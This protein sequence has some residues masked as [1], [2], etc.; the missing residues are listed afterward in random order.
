MNEA[1]ADSGELFFGA[2]VRGYVEDNPRR[3]V[4]R[5]WLAAQVDE[6][7]AK[8]GKPFVLLTAE[9]GAGKSAFMAQLAHDHPD[10]LRY[11]IRR[12]QAEPLADVSA[13]SLLLRIGYQLLA[14]SPELFSKEQLTL[15]IKQRIGEVAAQGE[16]VGVEVDKLITSPFVSKLKFE[17]EQQA[18]AIGGKV[19]G[20]RA[21]EMYIEERLLPTDDLLHLALIDPARALQRVDPERQLVIL[22]DA[23]DEI[24]YRPTADNI[25]AWLTNCPDLP[26]NIRFVLTSRPPDSA[27]RL[28][29]EKQ[30]SRLAKLAISEDDDNVTR[31]VAQFIAKWVGEP[32][33]AKELD[34]SAD[35]AAAFVAKVT[36]KATGNLGYLDALA[37]GLD[38]ALSEMD[39]KDESIRQ[40]GRRTLDGLLSLKELPAGLG[41]LYGLFLNQM[42]QSV[43][44]RQI[45]GKDSAGKTYS[46]DVWPAVYHPMLGVLAVAVEPLSQDL[47]AKLG[48]IAAPVGTTGLRSVASV[49]RHR[50]RPLSLLPRDGGGIP[51]GNEDARRS[52]HTRPLSGRDAIA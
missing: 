28:F 9:P 12:D 43:A 35:G 48:D 3:F 49:P 27:V 50:R 44:D 26:D 8:A 17:I 47:I 7:L 51:H 20:F 19:V 41:G 22:I 45:V 52:R 4:R 21:K 11:F 5:E 32:A 13:R 18:Q 15:S 2:L 23:L 39:A 24:H 14:R 34:A 10:W 38:Q 6:E 1:K 40:R 46:T 29:C 30:A 42:K 31:D 33:L 37:R 16:A 36:A 25:L